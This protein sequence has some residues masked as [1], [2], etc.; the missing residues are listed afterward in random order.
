MKEL[1]CTYH[2]TDTARTTQVCYKTS[3]FSSMEIDGKEVGVVTEYTFTK[4][5]EHSIKFT[6]KDNANISESVFALCENLVSITISNN[7][8]SIGEYAF[9]KCTSLISITIP[10]SVTSIGRRAFNK[11]FSLTSVTIPSSVTNIG[12]QPF[13]CCTG[14]ERII[15][16]KNN[17]AYEA[18]INNRF[19]VEK[20]TNEL[21]DFVLRNEKHYKIWQMVK[22]ENCK[23]A[24]LKEV[25]YYTVTWPNAF[26]HFFREKFLFDKDN[27]YNKGISFEDYYH[28]TITITCDRCIPSESK[29]F[30][31]EDG[32]FFYT[33]FGSYL[34]VSLTDAIFN[35]LKNEDFMEVENRCQFFSK[36]YLM[37]KWNSNTELKKIL[38]RL[39]YNPNKKIEDLFSSISK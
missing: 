17:S 1:I 23:N 25:G 31:Y 20:C 9:D 6:L 19:L 11:C 36:E 26:H 32:V 13:Y 30:I 8:T 18:R 39:K 7:V 22:S 29:H 34:N 21:I 28:N 15:V 33:E 24:K 12:N 37:E 14:L 35:I 16:D 5:G 10:N 3:D 4:T 2:I 38:E 27:I